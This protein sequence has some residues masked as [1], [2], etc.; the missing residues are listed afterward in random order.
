MMQPVRRV[1]VVGNSGSGKTRLA[2]A[3]ASRL[4][5]PHVELDALNH[6][7]GW[8]EAPVAEFRDE[9]RVILQEHEDRFGGWIADGNY[10]S[11]LADLLQPDTYVWLDY[12]RRVVLRRVVCR[13]LDRVIRR[14]ELWNGNRERWQN[15]VRRDPAENV[16][17]WSWTRH[18]SYRALY[19]DAASQ[20]A[21]ATWIRLRTP[22]ETELWLSR[23]TS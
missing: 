22:R 15:L 13:T 2:Q 7:A 11:R 1:C 19:E 21:S 17:L 23:L 9:V 14:R 10:R 12:P 6:R 5:V 8:Q 20:G 3:L 4:A 16:V 18:D